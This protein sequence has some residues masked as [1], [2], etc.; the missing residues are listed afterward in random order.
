MVNLKK[1][2]EALDEVTIQEGLLLDTDPEGKVVKVNLRS[3]WRGSDLGRTLD[4]SLAKSG[5]IKVL[6][7]CGDTRLFAVRTLDRVLTRAGY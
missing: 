7:P 5:K 3:A 1:V 2:R 6:A 4:F